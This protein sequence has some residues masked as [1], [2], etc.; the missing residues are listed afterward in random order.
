MSKLYV[1]SFFN[2]SIDY[3]RMTMA[4]VSGFEARRLK[5]KKQIEKFYMQQNDAFTLRLFEAFLRS[6]PQFTLQLYIWFF[7]KQ[8]N[9]LTGLNFTL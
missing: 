3:F 9:A 1:Y 8:K 7:T 5:G 6:A 2:I 4:L